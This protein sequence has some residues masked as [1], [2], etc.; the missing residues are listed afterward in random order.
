MTKCAQCGKE[1]EGVNYC[2]WQ[3]MVEFSKAQGGKAHLPNGLPIKSIRADCNMYEH[4]H[5]DHPDYKWPVEIDFV[6]PIDD[7][8]RSDF[9]QIAC[10]EPKDD[11]EVRRMQRQTHALIY[12]DG[13]IALTMYECN[14]ALWAVRDG[15]YLGGRYASKDMRLKVPLERPT[16]APVQATGM[17]VQARRLLEDLN[18]L[19]GARRCYPTDEAHDAAMVAFVAGEFSAASRRAEAQRVWQS[20]QALLALID[21]FQRGRRALEAAHKDL[22]AL[23]DARDKD[24]HGWMP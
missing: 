16:A 14:Y 5:G 6:G 10:R 21:A 15:A 19:A 9:E 18:M 1:N 11:D 8:H 13:S 4:E 3:C 22:Q 20:W 2:D 7:D 17:E 24:R 12:T 23:Q